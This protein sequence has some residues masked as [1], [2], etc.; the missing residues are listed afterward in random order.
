[1]HP[2]KPAKGKL[3]IAEP[4][5][6][7]SNFERSVVFICEHN[8]RGTFG[9][10]FNQS[11]NLF[12]NDVL[13]EPVVNSMPLYLGG[14]VEH[15]TLHFL[16][17]LPFIEEAV[18]VGD[19]LFWSGDFEQIISLLN[20]GK[21]TEHDI[22]FFIGYSGWSAGQLE[23]E[24]QK[25]AWIISQADARFIFDTPTDQFWRAVLRRMGGEYRVKSHYPIDPSLN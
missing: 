19:N 16:H 9:L 15:N 23:E 3:L 7:D 1:M 10:V 17:R 20:V 11:T 12:L 25:N 24:I 22:R 2:Q 13:K 14:P 21:I 6:G 4:F 18:P 5:L 8:E